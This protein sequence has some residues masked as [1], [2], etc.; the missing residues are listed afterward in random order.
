MA[1]PPLPSHEMLDGPARAPA[2]AM[3]RA[4]GYDDAAMA[5][6]MV[7][8]VNTWSNVTPCNIHL[9]GL[10]EHARRGIEEAGGTPVDFNTIVVTDG[11]SMGTKGMKASLMSRECIADSAEL[12][13]RGH[14]LD[15]VL[16]LVG[17]DKTLPGA[18]MAAA[19]SPP[20]R[21]RWR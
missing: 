1:T 20:T 6:P 8:I 2:R 13:V 9:R 21:W 15:A 3:L 11:I 17:C 5:K 19:S 14:S 10:A 12:A 18:A 16:F 4:A 7:A